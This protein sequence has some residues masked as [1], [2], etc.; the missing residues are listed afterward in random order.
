MAVKVTYEIFYNRGTRKAPD[1]GS[2]IRTLTGGDPDIRDTWAE[3]MEEA[4]KHI[5]SCS[6][7]GR[8]KYRIVKVEEKTEQEYA[9]RCLMEERKYQEIAHHHRLGIE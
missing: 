5:T 3:D 2:H 8:D 1:W 4:W 9:D 6:S 7:D